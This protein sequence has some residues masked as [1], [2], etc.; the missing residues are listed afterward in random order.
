M[1]YEQGD[2]SASNRWQ[3]WAQEESARLYVTDTHDSPNVIHASAPYT[4]P[5]FSPPVTNNMQMRDIQSST[6]QSELFLSDPP[7]CFCKQRSQLSY[8]LEYGPTFD[9]VSYNANSLYRYGRETT[10]GFHV[11]KA[12]W[13][14]M[15]SYINAGYKIHADIT[16]LRECP[17]YN[18]TFC[19]VFHLTNSYDK[20]P[21]HRFPDCYCGYPVELE[22]KMN[23]DFCSFFFVCKNLYAQS[24]EKCTCHSDA[25]VVL[26]AKSEHMSHTYIDLETYRVHENKQRA[27]LEQFEHQHRSNLLATLSSEST[28]SAYSPAVPASV[29]GTNQPFIPSSEATPV[30]SCVARNKAFDKLQKEALSLQHS[31]SCIKQ[32][33]KQRINNFEICEPKH[34]TNKIYLQS[35]QEI[36][37]RV[38]GQERLSNIEAGAVA[39]AQKYVQQAKELELYKE[40][41]GGKNEHNK[42]KICYSRDIEYILV[43]C[44][45]FGKYLIITIADLI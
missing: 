44:F 11:H 5:S 22:E 17:L 8:T 14:R 23:G 15:K 26:F 28:N 31:F 33:I 1:Q 2:D 25:K 16:D 40:K 32:D 7:L 39:L 3:A 43:P 38:N 27:L 29:L 13:D 41:Y 9:C 34:M 37:L 20:T 21:P 18:Y 24:G 4:V 6:E 35:K 30:T 12:S 10:C 42:C 45:H 19:N 36:I